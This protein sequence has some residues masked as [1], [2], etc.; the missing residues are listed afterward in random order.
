MSDR[1]L[2]DSPLGCMPL[3]E[4]QELCSAIDIL[5]CVTRHEHGIYRQYTHTFV[6]LQLPLGAKLHLDDYP[7]EDFCYRP[8]TVVPSAF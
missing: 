8:E 4:T 3:V 5:P 6:P 1:L 7:A 2:G